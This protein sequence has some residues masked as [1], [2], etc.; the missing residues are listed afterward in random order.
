MRMNECGESRDLD[1]K[2]RHEVERHGIL[3]VMIKNEDL[4]YEVKYLRL[5]ERGKRVKKRRKSV[6]PNAHLPDSY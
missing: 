1:E 5:W 4:D 2:T 3:K 6:G